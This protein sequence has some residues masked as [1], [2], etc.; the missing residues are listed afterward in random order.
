MEIQVYAKE[1]TGIEPEVDELNIGLKD[2][3]LTLL[4][5]EFNKTE[6]LDAIDF[7][8]IE[9]YYLANKSYDDED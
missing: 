2:V 3:D 6:L 4:V 1:I 5:G 7:S 8:D 9:E